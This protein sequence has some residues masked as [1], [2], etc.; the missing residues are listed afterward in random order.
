M[1]LLSP[2]KKVVPLVTGRAQS[3]EASENNDENIKIK[4]YHHQG[5][6]VSIH[7]FKGNKYSIFKK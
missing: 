6:A 2:Q 4:C 1:T 7:E 3:L 5:P